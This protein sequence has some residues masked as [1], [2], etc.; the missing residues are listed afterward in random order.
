MKKLVLLALLS[1]STLVGYSQTYNTTIS[2]HSYLDSTCGGVL[3]S[4]SI[5]PSNPVSV[6]L[7]PSLNPIGYFL[8]TYYYNA[9]L[10]TPVT[11]HIWAKGI[12]GCI[13]DT[14]FTATYDTTH[15]HSIYQFH[16]GGKDLDGVRW[17]SCPFADGVNELKTPTKNLVRIIDELGREAVPEPNKTF[18]YLYSDG[19]LERKIIIKE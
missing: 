18:I 13:F 12:C 11:Y 3:Q 19:T 14:T 17:T 4:V 5:L 6:W 7:A 10:D 15:P 16:V 8:A 1:L 9:P 2:V